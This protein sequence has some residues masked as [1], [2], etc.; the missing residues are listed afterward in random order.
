[1]SAWRGAFFA[2]VA[3][4]GHA[5]AQFRRPVS[6]RHLTS[7]RCEVGHNP[8]P[9]GHLRSSV[10]LRNEDWGFA[11]SWRASGVARVEGH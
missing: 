1:M 2:N 6:V 5:S 9:Q 8:G 10:S 4:R 11:M 7:R 3:H